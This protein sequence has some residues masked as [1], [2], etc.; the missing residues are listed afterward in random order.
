MAI[1]LIE[2]QLSII[3]YIYTRM[4]RMVLILSLLQVEGKDAID[5]KRMIFRARG[6]RVAGHGSG[7]A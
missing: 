4:V 3:L 2:H 1:I 7:M 6:V 5:A